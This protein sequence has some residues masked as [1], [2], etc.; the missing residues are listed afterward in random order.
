MSLVTG[1]SRGIGRAIAVRLAKGG[2]KV[3]VADVRKDGVEETARM[4]REAGGEAVPIAADVSKEDDVKRMIAEAVAALGG[5]DVLVNNAGVSTAGF[6]ESVPD[7]EIERI[8]SVNLFG[9]MRVTRAAVPHLKKSGRGRIVNLSSVE[10][11]RGSGLT[12]VYG[13]SKAGL[14]GLTRSNAVEL[15]RFGVTVNAICPGPIDTDMLA[16]LVADPKF[17]DKCIKGIPMKRLGKPEDIAGAA[18]FLASSESSFITGNVIVIDG[19][20]TVKAL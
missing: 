15:A 20:M 2:S 5:L 8:F 4:I 14:I 11:V 1:A 9:A 13:S 6:M 12:P 7:S 18:A 17:R 16:A 19:G 10:G 3:A